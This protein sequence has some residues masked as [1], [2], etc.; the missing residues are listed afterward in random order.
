M[1]FLKSK[2][3]NLKRL[4]KRWSLELR[5]A[6]LISL[7]TFLILWLIGFPVGLS[8]VIRILLFSALL[9]YFIRASLKR[10]TVGH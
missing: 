1:H 5:V 2:W 8:R 3:F 6:S 4:F 10:T 7:F 9:S